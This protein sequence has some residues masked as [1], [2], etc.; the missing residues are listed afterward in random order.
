MR[1]ITGR[2][3]EAHVTS[4]DDRFLHAGTFGQGSFVLNTGSKLEASIVTS[5]QIS[6]SSGDLIHNGTHARIDYGESESVTIE[7]GTTGYNRK[8]LIVARYTKSA[9]IESFELV[10]IKGTPT[11]GTAVEPDYNSESV[12]EGATVSDM[13]LYV[14]SISGVNITSVVQ[15]FKIATGLDDVYRKNEVYPKSSNLINSQLLNLIYPVGSIYMSTNSK[16]P[17]EIF[18][19]TWEAWGQGRAIVGVGTCN[20]G[21]TSK[22]FTNEQKVGEYNHKLSENEMPSHKHTTEDYYA[23]SATAHMPYAAI[24]VVNDIAGGETASGNKVTIAYTKNSYYLP[25]D[26]HFPTNDFVYGEA[27]RDSGKTGGS[28]THNNIQPSIAC[29]MWKRIK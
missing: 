8:D 18:G 4:D 17:G 21:T 1:I 6:I 15:K 26:V 16:N 3:G 11:S 13:P 29:Y 14:V 19:G 2:T 25:S 12:L 23:T 27:S 7:N 20:D 24:S 22:T 28:A 9:G 10:A 5:N